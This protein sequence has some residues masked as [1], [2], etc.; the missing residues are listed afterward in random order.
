MKLLFFI[1]LLTI[2]LIASGGEVFITSPQ[3]GY[4]LRDQQGKL[5]L[6][7]YVLFTPGEDTTGNMGKVVCGD[8]QGPVKPNSYTWKIQNLKLN[9]E[10]Y[11]VITCS[12]VRGNQTSTKSITVLWSK[13]NIA[14]TAQYSFTP[15]SGRAP[16]NVSFDAS[17]SKDPDGSIVFYSWNFGDGTTANG[18]NVTHTFSS[19]GN[20]GI[21]LT[22]LDNENTFTSV[23]KYL[24]VDI[25]SQIPVA[26]IAANPVTGEIPLSVSFDASLSNDPD[27]GSLKEYHF[28]FGDGTQEITTLPYI[29]HVYQ[30]EGNY[31]AFL[32]VKD[33]EDELSAPV[34]INIQSFRPNIPPV[35]QIDS[36][37]ISG[38]PPLEVSFSGARSSDADGTIESYTWYFPNGV[39]KT[40]IEVTHVFE[41]SGTFE[42]TLVVK[43][44]RNVPAESK[45]SINVDSDEVGPVLAVTPE[46]NSFIRTGTPQFEI[47]HTDS[48]SGIDLSSIKAYLDG[49][50]ISSRLQVGNE[51]S[52]LAFTLANPISTGF[53]ELRFEVKDKAGNLSVLVNNYQV[54]LGEISVS[55]IRGT[56]LDVD[57]NPIEGVSIADIYTAPNVKINVSTDAQGHYKIPFQQAGTYRLS[58]NKS[59]FTESVRTVTPTIVEDIDLGLVY[60]G[61]ADSV[62]TPI[63]ASSGGTA[64]NSTGSMNFIFPPGVLPFDVDVSMTEFTDERTLPGPLP[65]MS[66]FT[67]AFDTRPQGV[68]LSGEATLNLDNSL[69]FPVGTPIV[70][71]LFDRQ[72]GRWLDSGKT[73]IVG[74]NKDVG[75]PIPAD[76][77][78]LGDPNLPGSCEN[79][80]CKPPAGGSAG[81]GGPCTAKCCDVGGGGGS[82]AGPGVGPSGGGGPGNPPFFSGGGDLGNFITLSGTLQSCSIDTKTGDLSVDHTL[83]S[84][85]MNGAKLS[86][87]FSYHSTHV[88]PQFFVDTVVSTK[89]TEAPLLVKSD[90]TIAGQSFRR[91]Y[92]GNNFPFDTSYRALFPAKN[93]DGK[94]F[95]TG[96]YSYSHFVTTSFNSQYATA[97]Y[98]G[99]PP[100]ALLD[101]VTRVP[102]S[103]STEV[104][105]KS[106]IINKRLSSFGAGWGIDGVEQLHEGADGTI[107]WENGGKGYTYYTP[108]N[109]QSTL[110]KKIPNLKSGLTPKLDTIS[111]IDGVYYGTDCANN[112]VYRLSSNGG[113][114]VVAGNG[115]SG[116]SGDEGLAT[117]ASLNCPLGLAKAE[118]GGFY[119]ADSDNFRIR[120]VT[121]NGIIKTVAYNPGGK[122]TSVSEDKMRAV[123]FTTSDSVM[124]VSPRG[125]LFTYSKQT[126]GFVEANLQNPTQVLFNHED[127]PIVIDSN[128]NRIITLYPQGKTFVKN[129]N[130]GSGKNKENISPKKIVFDSVLRQFYLLDKKGKL[131][132]WK[133][134]GNGKLHELSLNRNFE[135]EQNIYKAKA[136]I[137]IKDF[138]YSTEMGFGV[139]AK[140]G[141]LLLSNSAKTKSTETNYI[142]REGTF[143]QL[144]K[145]SDGTFEI[146]DFKNNKRVFD[147]KGRLTAV[148]RPGQDNI[149]YLYNSD[150][151]LERINVSG[152]YFYFQ[153]DGRGYL[154][155]VRDSSN[156]LTNF[157]I[158]NFGRLTN[159]EKPDG[160]IKSYNYFHDS[161]LLSEEIDEKGRV[162][163]FEY[164]RG[165]IIKETLPGNRVRTYLPEHLKNNQYPTV[166]YPVEGNPSR[167][168]DLY[169]KIT[170]KSGNCELYGFFEKGIASELRDCLGNK[171]KNTISDDAKITKTTSPEGR[172]NDFSYDSLGRIISSEKSSGFHSFDYDESSGKISR[173]TDSKSNSINIEYDFSGKLKKVI[174]EDN[175]ATEM[176]YDSLGNL[177]EIRNSNNYSSSMEYDESNNL[178]AIIDPLNNRIEFSRDSSGNITSVK[179]SQ[180][181]ISQF[182]Y[183]ELNRLI[184]FYNPLN[185]ATSFSY[186][187]TGKLQTI[188]DANN[189]LTSLFYDNDYDLLS[190][191][192]NPQNQSDFY[193]YNKDERLKSKTSKDG[194]GLNLSYDTNGRVILKTNSLESVSYDYD[195]DGYPTK[196]TN[197]NYVVDLSYDQKGR[198]ATSKT[199]NVPGELSYSYDERGLKSGVSYR[200]G[201]TTI[202]SIE[203]TYND[204]K[205]L[206][207]MNANLMGHMISWE[208]YWD[209]LSRPE[210]DVLSN[211]LKIERNYD[212]AGRLTYLSTEKDPSQPLA[213]FTYEM[214]STGTIKKIV[215]TFTRPDQG[216]LGRIESHFSYDALDRLINSSS[217]GMISYD[218]VGNLTFKN[219]AFNSLNHLLSNDSFD[220]SYTSNGS[221]SEKV[222]KL[223]GQ[224]FKY[225]WGDEN[226]LL[227]MVKTN[228]QGSIID[229][230]RF[231]YDPMDR[232][233]TKSVNG[234]TRKFVYDDN[235]ILIEFGSN[236][237]LNAIYLHGPNIDEPIAMIRDV[238]GNGEFSNEEIFYYV[239]DHLG[240]IHALV[241]KDGKPVQR[242]SYTSYGETKVELLQKNKKFIYNPYAFTSR[243]WEEESGD[244]YLRARYYDPSS[245]RFLSED[246][247]YFKSGNPN[248]Y[249]YVMGNP[250]SL[251]D[252]TGLKTDACIDGGLIP[253]TYLCVDGVCGG[254]GPTDDTSGWDAITKVTPGVSQGGI[255]EPS[256]FPG[257]SSFGGTSCEQIPGDK[258]LDDCVLKEL[259]NPN[260]P[261][262]NALS[263]GGKNCITYANDV[264]TACKAQC[265]GNSNK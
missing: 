11:N 139:I 99:G 210:L 144:T 13:S 8:K 86:L 216:S 265:A 25:P 201:S 129:F 109:I 59:G 45:V 29:T 262:Y 120:R 22:V 171:Y 66:M 194:T 260:K 20:Y 259:Q 88:E 30:G 170:T 118:T 28:D 197:N 49:N 58:F 43:D 15:Q 263:I 247:L 100:A 116:F 124:L 183:D 46:N 128:N 24:Y 180:N 179:D 110:E 114:E 165:K 104:T 51:S 214:N 64:Q 4:I 17:Q 250:V 224:S 239:K 236:N 34:S 101:V 53:H 130:G 191:I 158:D 142:S 74:A 253:H 133:G 192:Q 157:E 153:Y 68:R 39:I 18:K 174:D 232:R 206:I 225:T 186:S 60:L 84:L 198:V 168:S 237:E 188:T 26:Q 75:M 92:D 82:G 152:G 23:T 196:I 195:N 50:D 205:L 207:G 242:Y 72:L 140:D 182:E 254:L 123:Y 202:V 69:G 10:G 161:L 79:G 159:I 6:E 248:F 87:S 78:P 146:T 167:P 169:T 184:G 27:G 235:D 35:A 175:Y 102:I 204:R 80:G 111:N 163:S 141:S 132:V 113:L 38:Y 217:D 231:T 199:S 155:S 62:V 21:T 145:K 56:V 173:I 234:L 134:L 48:T 108:I 138:T 249:S 97:A 228:S 90:I 125:D 61:V 63:A 177:I 143:D 244:Y 103:F 156:R 83:P 251:T 7:G 185:N 221:L 81:G 166:D 193:F 233:V 151:Q 229:D 215:H 135:I 264:V 3:N 119:I 208:R 187:P 40:G 12:Y 95:E 37:T 71:G 203:Y 212:P 261:K 209:E 31:T 164:E 220:Y 96:A 148:I 19:S 245:G 70:Y 258:C 16:L 240:S 122:P 32:V 219:G 91:T 93:A 255:G 94:Y 136:S 65:V 57:N 112:Y 181:R 218:A 227:K 230:V 154:K 9:L 121:S 115:K 127:Y 223:T 126:D 36:S 189:N 2:S 73:V 76:E 172:V 77:F 54:D 160:S 162:K 200:V 226:K 89:D 176:S 52:I 106:V 42:V 67:Y 252:P 44:N 41:Q 238:D 257:A 137:P 213:R 150:N 33:T 1:F 149:V 211:G 98:F 14:P 147:T 107:L 178:M 117:N 243:E 241:D 55:Y 190:Q 246:P 47:S 222:S 131:F 85:F 105:D 256:G 5:D